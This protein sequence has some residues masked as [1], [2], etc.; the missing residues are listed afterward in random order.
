MTIRR[1]SVGGLH[2]KMVADHARLSCWAPK[3]NQKARYVASMMHATNL[4]ATRVARVQL[5]VQGGRRDTAAPKAARRQCFMPT[6][7]EFSR[8]GCMPP[9][10]ATVTVVSA[11]HSRLCQYVSSSRRLRQSS[12]KLPRAH[13]LTLAHRCV[14]DDEI[15]WKQSISW[16]MLML[17]WLLSSENLA[18]EL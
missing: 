9:A 12:Q 2:T 3:F 15:W 4:F 17:G 5:R 1:P 11:R 10:F 8:S 6:Q 14:I 7:P 18:N 16:L 13:H